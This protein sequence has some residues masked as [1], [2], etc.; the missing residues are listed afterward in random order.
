V[1]MIPNRR[2]E[3][4]NVPLVPWRCKFVF[5]QFFP[6]GIPSRTGF[7]AHFCFAFFSNT[8]F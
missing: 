4:P 7:P 2:R 6:F 8:T 3:A 5:V 1:A